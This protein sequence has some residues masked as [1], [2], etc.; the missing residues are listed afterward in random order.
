MFRGSGT[1]VAVIDAG[2]R[3]LKERVPQGRSYDKDAAT[4]PPTDPHPRQNRPPPPR[5]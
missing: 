1:V 2:R 3:D 5:R 4:A